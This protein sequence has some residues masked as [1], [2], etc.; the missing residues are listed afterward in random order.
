MKRTKLIT[1]ATGLML[2]FS[3]SVF[4]DEKPL[5]ITPE[6][7]AYADKLI[8]LSKNDQMAVINELTNIPKKI[9]KDKASLAGIAEILNSNRLYQPALEIATVAYQDH[10]EY[11]PAI[12]AMGNAFA[13]LGNTDEA[14]AKYEEA[15]NAD[16][17][18][19]RAYFKFVDIYK[20]IAPEVALEKLNVIKEKFPDDPEINKAMGSI[21]YNQNKIDDAE[22]AYQEY[23]KS[24][25]EGGD[26]QAQ[27]DYGIVLFAKK[28]YQASL[29][30]AEQALKHDASSLSANR[31]K[32]YNLMELAETDKA[33]AQAGQFFGKFDEKLYNSTDY[34]YAADLASQTND[35]QLA[36]KSYEKAVKLNP[37]APDLYKS[38]SEAYE[39]VNQ[40]DSAVAA[41]MKYG[42]L[43]NPGALLNY[44]Q[45]GKIYYSAA[46]ALKDGE[47]DALRKH[48]INA[49][50]SLF[51][52]VSEKA[53]DSYMGPFWRARIQTILDPNNPIESVKSQYEEA[54]RRMEGKD[55][56]YDGYRKECLV[57]DAFYYFKKDQ[58]AA[59][60]DACNKVLAIEPNNSLCKQIKAAIGQLRK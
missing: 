50:D 52:R 5:Q 26:P 31:L 41:Y 9:K 47:H 28:N 59:S 35:P 23:F 21:Y 2:T 29:A 39:A 33:K 49:G 1:L 58:Y 24:I 14:A 3:V 34:K 15:I 38:L 53:P 42:E 20:N 6:A 4:A 16:P 25:P 60:L 54:Y 19:K 18:D 22:K 10:P 8:Q 12:L 43:A 36:V 51:A 44:L 48:Y 37:K 30:I 57:Y 46:A 40:T 27:E 55:D 7:Q 17:S 11:L 13:G 32:F 45:A 56:S